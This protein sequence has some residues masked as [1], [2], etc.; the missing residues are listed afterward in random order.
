MSGKSI[1]T[2][3]NTTESEKTIVAQSVET[4]PAAVHESAAASGTSRGAGGA[5]SGG[6]KTGG[7]KKGS[8][9][10]KTMILEQ[11]NEVTG[12]SPKGKGRM[13]MVVKAICT[14]RAKNAPAPVIAH[15]DIDGGRVKGANTTYKMR[16]DP[17]YFREIEQE[18]AR[19]AL[20]HNS[21][22]HVE[23][24]QPARAEKPASASMSGGG[25]VKATGWSKSGKKKAKQSKIVFVEV[26]EDHTKAP[27]VALKKMDL[28]G[29]S[30]W[31]DARPVEGKEGVVSIKVSCANFVDEEVKEKYLDCID[32]LVASWSAI[33]YR[34][35]NVDPLKIILS[36]FSLSTVS[37]C[38]GI[39]LIINF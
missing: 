29:F 39:F 37:N 6:K 27:G 8:K 15:V 2:L 14:I 23:K 17:K 20:I 35:K 16:G 13:P 21:T 1:T 33:K 28:K 36:I 10:L 7:Q 11:P 12:K 19:L 31:N 32:N 22:Q 18:L 30:A 34:L 5:G 9:P 38:S 3:T 26:P 24:K 4:A 25:P